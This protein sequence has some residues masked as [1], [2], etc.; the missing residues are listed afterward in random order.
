MKRLLSCM[1]TLAQLCFAL[2]AFGED[3]ATPWFQAPITLCGKEYSLPVPLSDLISDGFVLE[4]SDLAE[5]LGPNYY[6][7]LTAK[8]DGVRVT[9]DVI[10]LGIDVK[11]V[12]DCLVS[13]VRVSASDMKNGATLVAG[14]L[15]LGK[16]TQDE[17]LAAVGP[18]ARLYE[19][20][21]YTSLDFGD[22]S[23]VDMGTQFEDG[24]LTS[25]EFSY[26]V[27]PE[28][29]NDAAYAAEVSEPADIASYAAPEALGT[30]LTS[31]VF[32]LNGVLYKMPVPYK[33][34]L[35][36]GL[37]VLRQN[38]AAKI[39]AGDSDI[40]GGPTLLLGGYP[41]DVYLKNPQKTAMPREY[42]FVTHLR[43]DG[44]TVDFELP[45]GIKVGMSTADLENALSGV[46]F[47]KSGSSYEI[48]LG[49][50]SS[51]EIY[52]YED[53]VSSVTFD[54]SL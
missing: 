25:L 46:T 32:R 47:E 18:A 6:T 23:L 10:N 8:L 49:E 26:R 29:Y 36:N 7:L 53:A 20:T 19:G 17:A 13:G 1:L 54:L 11:T 27:T 42:C 5:E 16:T 31:G 44:T 3:A 39:A 43:V 12:S 41:L 21:S 51:I 35:E 30:D 34:F 52:T 45:G 9:L 22:G 14:T 33:V 50:R 40:M 24:V 15:E 37:T 2:P 4:E 28:G 48:S 38:S